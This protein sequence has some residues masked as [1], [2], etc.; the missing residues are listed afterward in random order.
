MSLANGSQNWPFSAAL[1]ENLRELRQARRHGGC[2]VACDRDRDDASRLPWNTG[3]LYGGWGGHAFHG[4]EPGADRTPVVFVHGNQRDACD[5]LSHAEFFLKRSY[6]GDE[7]WAV[8]FRDG[9]P[10][11]REMAA[12]LAD[13]VDQVRNHTGA[14]QVAVVAHSLGVTGVRWWL[15]EYDCHGDVETVVSLAGANHGSVLNKWAANAGISEETYKVTPFLRAD[16]HRHDDHPLIR[17]NEDET[18]GDI[19]YY[20]LR[21]TEDPLFWGC[22]D[23]PKLEGATNVALETD[24]DGVRTDQHAMELVFEWVSGD[25]PHDLSLQVGLPD[26][27]RTRG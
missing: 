1:R 11:H 19:D 16:Y 5:W 9:S 27:R 6:L 2:S 15:S 3:G 14:E 26:A 24:H 18:P 10:S 25:H 21:G 7:L 20:T 17:L 4:T 22:L 23:S 8:T 13:F 12:T